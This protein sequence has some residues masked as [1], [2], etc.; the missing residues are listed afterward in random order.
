MKVM[1]QSLPWHKV[2]EIFKQP[3]TNSR[4][5]T[6]HYTYPIRKMF[7]CTYKD[8]FTYDLEEGDFFII[9][10]WYRGISLLTAP[11]NI[12]SNI[13]LSRL[14][15]EIAGNHQCGFRRKTST[16]DHIL[17]LPIEAPRYWTNNST[18]ELSSHSSPQKDGDPRHSSILP[19]FSPKCGD[20]HN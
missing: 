17:L 6:K 10:L 13:L 2:R 7:K 18:G 15:D 4:S 11:H 8:L 5:P 12:W 9:N 20:L 14:Q 19:F 16:T 1:F 3:R